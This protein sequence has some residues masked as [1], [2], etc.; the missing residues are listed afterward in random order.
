MAPQVTWSSTFVAQRP[1]AVIT[2]PSV[3]A[4]TTAARFI[5]M[6]FNLCVANGK[7]TVETP[8]A[9]CFTLESGGDAAATLVEHTK[10]E[11]PQTLVVGLAAVTRDDFLR[12]IEDRVVSKLAP[13]SLSPEDFKM[14]QQTI[15]E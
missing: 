8:F 6:V 7:V 5:A 11:P 3:E 13:S 9:L 2:L 15:V 12:A 1:T 14:L 4:D 10:D